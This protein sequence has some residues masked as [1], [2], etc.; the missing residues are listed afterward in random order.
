MTLRSIYATHPGEYWADSEHFSGAINN[1]A[2]NDLRSGHCC[3][4][5]TIS[6][7][8][9]C[10]EN[11]VLG[12]QTIHLE[13][14]V[15]CHARCL[16]NNDISVFLSRLGGGSY[17]S[18]YLKAWCKFH[19]RQLWPFIKCSQERV[20]LGSQWCPFA[21]L[22]RLIPVDNQGPKIFSLVELEYSV[23]LWTMVSLAPIFLA[24]T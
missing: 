5:R 12:L 20:H 13:S 19:Q 23:P 2:L 4:K 7:L 1:H 18:C 8:A 11:L 24:K 16:K 9:S 15:R 21:K 14:W 17:C 10:H 22:C 6:D 3:G